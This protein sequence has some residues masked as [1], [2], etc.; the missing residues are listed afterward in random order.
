MDP[1]DLGIYIDTGKESGSIGATVFKCC[2]H[3]Q[4][5]LGTGGVGENLDKEEYCI[6]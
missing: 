2:L 6:E 4:I 1:A 5:P 3:E